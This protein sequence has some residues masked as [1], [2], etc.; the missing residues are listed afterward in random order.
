MERIVVGVDGSE[1]SIRALRWA[2]NEGR[3]RGASV[4]AVMVE[5]YP[6]VV[7]VPG[8]AFPVE[9]YESVQKRAQARLERIL[10]EQLGTPSDVAVEP[11]A[12]LGSAAKELLDVAQGADLLVVGA[13]GRGGFASLLLGSVSLQ[14]ALY[15]PCPVLIIRRS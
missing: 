7:G 12:V 2:V 9:P 10:A 13:R 11:R 3:L 15:A 1:H 6:D 14:C 8:A 4:E 5:P